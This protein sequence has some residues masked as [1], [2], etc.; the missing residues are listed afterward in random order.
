MD[1]AMSRTKGAAVAFE[2]PPEFANPLVRLAYGVD[3][4]AEALSLS[5]SRIY[6]LIA[7]GEI[8]ACKVGKR[9]IIPAAELTAFLDRHR[10]ARLS[11]RTAAT[12]PC[13]NPAPSPRRRN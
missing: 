2:P 5:R 12:S 9:T 3:D 11:G 1:A 4:T 10:V 7:S 8:A 6:E 13:V